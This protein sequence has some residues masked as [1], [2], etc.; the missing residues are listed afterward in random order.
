MKNRK[1]YDNYFSYLEK[2]LRELLFDNIQTQLKA[3]EIFYRQPSLFKFL[4]YSQKPSVPIANLQKQEEALLYTLGAIALEL[5]DNIEQRKVK[6]N[7]CK[8]YE[9][10]YSKVQE[11]LKF[12]KLKLSLDFK[13]F[14]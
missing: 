12:Y 9:I 13:K 6:W 11:L 1:I 8:T 4:H 7:E 3:P 5:L 10:H 14:I 2:N